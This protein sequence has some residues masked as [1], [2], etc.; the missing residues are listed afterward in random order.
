MRKRSGPR[1]WSVSSRTGT[2]SVARI[3]GRERRAAR[4]R[5]SQARSLCVDA[6]AESLESTCRRIPAAPGSR[7]ATKAAGFEAFAM[8]RP[9]EAAH[10][11]AP[12]PDGLV[13][14]LAF[15]QRMRAEGRAHDQAERAE[16]T[17]H[18]FGQI[19]S[20][21]VL[22][23]LAAAARERAVGTH[24]RRCRRSD[25]EACRS[26]SRRGPN[27][28]AA[29]RPPIVACSGSAGSSA[30]RC[31]CGASVAC[32][33]ASV[34]PASTNDHVGRR[35]VDHAVRA[36]RI[37]ENVDA[38]GLV[39]EPEIRSA[40]DEGEAFAARGTLAYEFGRLLD[41]LGREPLDGRRFAQPRPAVPAISEA[42]AT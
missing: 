32:N 19:E 27:P 26:A 22:D 13:P 23:D 4:T 12:R 29:N 39:A 1:G 14:A 3:L 24:D 34:M 40:A 30:R 2:P 31:A 35:I 41:T 8:S 11:S 17:N 6:R 18:Q 42:C 16:R 37:D 36:L 21:D 25:R 28:L 20:G 5:S 33:A 38:L 9:A 7:R 15:G 10:V